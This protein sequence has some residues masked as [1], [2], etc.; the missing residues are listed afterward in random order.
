VIHDVNL[1]ATQIL[2]LYFRHQ[3]FNSFQRQLNYFGFKKRN[4]A[5]ITKRTTSMAITAKTAIEETGAA[6][7]PIYFFHPFFQRERPELWPRVQRQAPSKRG[8]AIAIS[9]AEKKLFHET[10]ARAEEIPGN[11]TSPPLSSQVFLEAPSQLAPSVSFLPVA[12]PQ[13]QQEIASRYRYPSNQPQ[14]QEY[15]QHPFQ[16][17][18]FGRTPWLASPGFAAAALHGP[19]TTFQDSISISPTDTG[20]EG[21]V[22]HGHFGQSNAIVSNRVQMQHYQEEKVSILSSTLCLVRSLANTCALLQHYSLI[23]M[24]NYC[25]I[26]ANWDHGW[27][28]RSE[29]SVQMSNPTEGMNGRAGVVAGQYESN[30]L[31]QDFS[32][33]S[34]AAGEPAVFSPDSKTYSSPPPPPPPT[35]TSPTAASTP[36]VDASVLRTFLDVQFWFPL[37][38]KGIADDEG[39][40][41]KMNQMID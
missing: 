34:V 17:Q 10:D 23:N 33:L 12:V 9:R 2:P 29:L 13:L 3:N 21:A 1:F 7:V 39:H 36:P 31:F 19:S 26:D 28:F 41:P 27:G 25:N 6:V 35:P 38:D 30:P 24:V 20:Q 18:Q 8:S 11:D 40:E 16:E 22:L 15:L 32:D 37:E 5:R 14:S 4:H